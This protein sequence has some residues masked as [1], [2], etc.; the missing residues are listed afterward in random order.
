MLL[1]LLV[2]RVTGMR[3]DSAFQEFVAAPLGLKSTRF[4][5]PQAWRS[6]VPPTE[7]RPGREHPVRG[8]VHDE[9]AAGL[10]GVS[11]HAG[12]FSTAADLAR[13]ARVLLDRGQTE[14]GRLFSEACVELFTRPAGL[15]A[16]SH[17]CLGWCLS[18]EMNEGECFSGCAYGHTGFTGT[19]LWIDPGPGV[20]LVLL[21]NAVHPRRECKAPA[22][23]TWRRRVEQGLYTAL[24]GA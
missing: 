7:L 24:F 22:Y 13:L 11:G 12:L 5:P 8:T 6:R 3:L 23:F 21:S 9:N 10:D 14:G 20:F 19:S 15:V 17:R 2:E 4:R 16:G 1:G 18:R